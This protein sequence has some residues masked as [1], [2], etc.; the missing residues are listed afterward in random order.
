MLIDERFTTND[1]RIKH[2]D[3]LYQMALDVI[4]S[5]TID[6]C[7]NRAEAARIPLGVVLTFSDVLKDP[8]LASRTFWE[9]SIC[10]DVEI[11]L[12]RGG[13]QLLDD[14][15]RSVPSPGSAEKIRKPNS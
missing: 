6:E 1:L 3:V 10:D 13:Y 2:R 15:N 11:V 5:W 8:H 14:K 12:P 4:A 7:I 9:P